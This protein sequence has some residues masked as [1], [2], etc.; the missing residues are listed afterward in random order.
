MK[1]IFFFTQ[2]DPD[3]RGTSGNEDHTSE[4]FDLEIT[5]ESKTR[6]EISHCK[7]LKSASKETDSTGL[8]QLCYCTELAIQ[9]WWSDTRFSFLL[10]GLSTVSLGFLGMLS[11]SGGLEY[12]IGPMYHI[13]SP[14]RSRLYLGMIKS[15]FLLK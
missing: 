9:K 11:G 14:K 10:P 12:D 6:D 13:V 5:L 1:I 15:I 8:R 3:S 2:E 7:T 4:S